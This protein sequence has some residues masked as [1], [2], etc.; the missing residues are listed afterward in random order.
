[1][2][3]FELYLDKIKS[4]IVDLSKKNQIIVPENFNGINEIGRAHV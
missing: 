4:L 2:N 3:I 1:M